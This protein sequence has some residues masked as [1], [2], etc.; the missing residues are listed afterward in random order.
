MKISDIE[1]RDMKKGQP[2]KI[3]GK[4]TVD[5]LV[6]RFQIMSQI[7]YLDLD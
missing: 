3:E 5:I 7:K 4:A 1:D 2:E 6:H